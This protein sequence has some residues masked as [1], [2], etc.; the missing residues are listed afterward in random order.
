MVVMSLARAGVYA[1]HV[2]SV[3]GGC[4][5]RTVD[6]FLQLV[7]ETVPVL[8][9]QFCRMHCPARAV[10]AGQCLG[11]AVEV[12]APADAFGVAGVCGE[13]LGHGE[14]PSVG[15]WSQAKSSVWNGLDWDQC[16]G[17]GAERS[18]LETKKAH[19]SVSFF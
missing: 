5:L 12:T 2:L 16:W 15:G 13:F 18:V 11:W 4:S 17:K 7:I 14:L 3:L 8:A 9:E 10:A 6:R 19:L 1:V